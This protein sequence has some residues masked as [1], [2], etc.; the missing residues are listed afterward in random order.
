[1]ETIQ[2]IHGKHGNNS[3]PFFPKCG[4]ERFCGEFCMNIVLKHSC[5]LIVFKHFYFS[6]YVGAV[7]VCALMCVVVCTYTLIDRWLYSDVFLI[8]LT[9][10]DKTSSALFLQIPSAFHIHTKHVKNWKLICPRI[11]HLPQSFNLENFKILLFL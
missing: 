3:F 9:L 10:W 4:Y 11:I 7:H 2:I 8:N 1:M 6:L 5:I